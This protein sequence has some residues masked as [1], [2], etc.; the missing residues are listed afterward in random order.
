MK[1]IAFI[2]MIFIS[3][4]SYISHIDMSDNPESAQD[5]ISTNNTALQEEPVMP[6][7]NPDCMDMVR[8]KVLQVLANGYALAYEC[9]EGDFCASNTVVLLTPLPRV[10]YYDDMYVTVPKEKCAVQNGVFRYETKREILKTVPVIKYDYEYAPRNNEEIEA[11]FYEAMKDLRLGCKDSMSFD[12]KTNNLESM[13]K[14]DCVVDSFLA[15]YKEKD[16]WI[17]RDKIVENLR[18]K[19]EAKCGKIPDYF[20]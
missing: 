10:Y 19:A 11:R 7:R 1:K 18:K 20:N 2:L 8:F 14:C 6:G 3:S 9:N 16:T 5:N 4:C 15:A 12:D 17:E 13:K